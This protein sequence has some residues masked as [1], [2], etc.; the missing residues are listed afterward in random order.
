[1]YQIPLIRI[2]RKQSKTPHSTRQLDFLC[3]ANREKIRVRID[4][5][6][7]VSWQLLAHPHAGIIVSNN[8]IEMLSIDCG[9]RYCIH[10]GNDKSK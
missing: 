6:A 1:M 3:Y 5:N 9:E 8:Y 7:N 4:W 2:K 10:H